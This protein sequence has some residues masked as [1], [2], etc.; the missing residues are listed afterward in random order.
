MAIDNSFMTRKIQK[1]EQIIVAFCAYTQMPF[2]S[3]DE[4][5]GND[6][7]WMFAS[8]KDLQNF[9]K[10]YTE[11]KL[12]LRGV[13]YKNKDFLRFFG[14]LFAMGVNELV[15]VENATDF[16]IA[17][18][19]LV[20]RPDYSNVPKERQPMLNPVLQLTG[21]YFMQEAA[22]PVPNEQ[23]DG[24]KDLEEEFAANLVKGRFILPIEVGEGDEPLQEK[25]KNKNYKLPILKD[26]KDNLF[27][28]L[29]SDTLEMEKFAHGK[30]LNAIIVPFAQLPRLITKE[31]K[32]FILNPRGYHI[33]LT[34][35]LLEGLP[36]R[37]Q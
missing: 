13:I 12:L 27:Q 3:C 23:K 9:A 6:Q 35:E 19:D 4:E 36:K 21:M 15:Y 18:T 29:L 22:R 10:P 34:K 32:G 7:I 26:K 2:V 17:L 11:K 5:S 20:R 24:L 8:E 25:L 14:S 37:F 33:V 30:Q 28:P 1:M 16:H 31:A